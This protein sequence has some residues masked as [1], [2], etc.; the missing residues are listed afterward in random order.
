MAA[1][2]FQNFLNGWRND[3]R[4]DL[5]EDPQD[6]IGQR[7]PACAEN[8]TDAF[9]DP[10][11]IHSYVNPLTSLTHGHTLTPIIGRLPNLARI[12]ELCER[13]FEWA[14]PIEILPK[15][16]RHIW[17]GLVLRMIQDDISNADAAQESAMHSSEVGF[18]I[19]SFYIQCSL[20]HLARRGLFACIRHHHSQYHSQ[21]NTGG[22]A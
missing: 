21:A 13:Y 16:H 1:D 5:R 7:N 18:C 6:S 10:T 3:L 9:P 19:L 4:Q 2:P 15:F 11:V 22:H 8:V 20:M 14:T 12:G 17:P